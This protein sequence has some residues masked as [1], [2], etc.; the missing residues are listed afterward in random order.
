MVGIVLFGLI[1]FGVNNYLEP[2]WEIMSISF[3]VSLAILVLTVLQQYLLDNEI[4][5]KKSKIFFSSFSLTAN[6]LFTL[7]LIG[8]SIYSIFCS[9][10]ASI[11]YQH[12]GDNYSP[13]NIVSTLNHFYKEHKEK[14]PYVFQLE[15]N[16]QSN[17]NYRFLFLIDNTPSADIENNTVKI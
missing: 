13:I 16:N 14:D 1:L 4:S 3:V 11:I 5:I 8:F 10:Y 15:K 7:F 9:I 17:D 12:S 2:F 6:I